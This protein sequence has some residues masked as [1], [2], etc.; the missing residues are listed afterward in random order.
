MRHWGWG[1]RTQ[2]SSYSRIITRKRWCRMDWRK[3]S[4]GGFAHW[5][6]KPWMC[7]AG[8]ISNWKGK[9]SKICICRGRC[10]ERSRMINWVSWATIS[11]R[12]Q[13]RQ[14]WFSLRARENRRWSPRTTCGSQRLWL[15][16]SSYRGKSSQFLSP[17]SW[18]KWSRTCCQAS[19]KTTWAKL[20]TRRS[21]TVKLIHSLTSTSLSLPQSLPLS[22][23]T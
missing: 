14:S 1:W 13:S 22:L 3:H 10:R 12:R 6:L 2:I 11:Q 7:L 9:W 20:S 5:T 4:C 19:S 18:K 16:G 17:S 15:G 21:E 8:R 23:G